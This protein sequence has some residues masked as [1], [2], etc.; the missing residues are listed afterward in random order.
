LS[1]PRDKD[2]ADKAPDEPH[3]GTVAENPLVDEPGD[4]KK[5]AKD[6]GLEALLDYLRQNRGY[7]FTGYKRPSLSR[8]IGKR[9]REVGIEAFS[10]YVDYLEVHPEE[11]GLLFDT[12]LINVTAF[13]RDM[14]AWEYVMR[15]VV[16]RIL[17]NKRADESI[18]LWSAGCAS[19]EE[20][21]TLAMVMAEAMGFEAFRNRVKIYATDIDEAALAHARQ[22]VYD[23]RHIEGIPE[24]LL[25]KYFET[26]NGRYSFHKDLRRSVI[27]GR[28]DLVQDAPIS[29]I[30][31]LACRNTLMYF[32]TET[33]ARILSRFHFALNEKGFLFLGKAETMQAYGALFTPVDFKLRVYSKVSRGHLR[34]RLA[35]LARNGNGGDLSYLLNHARLRDSAFDAGAVPQI[36][37]DINGL[38]VLA[39]DS[40]RKLFS[41]SQ[42]DLDQ[43]L[44]NLQISYRPVELRSCID[45]AYKERRNN[46]L[47]EVKWALEGGEPRFL[48]IHVVPL[49][50][51][52]GIL[53]GAS[54][55]FIDVSL[56]RR[57]KDELQATN[58]ALE[59]TN[60]ELQS[61]NEEL[62][63]TNEELQST[64]EELETTNEELQSTN[65]E[66]ETMNEELQSTN[67]E[68]E[69]IN[70][71][72]RQ[73]TLDLD[74]AN[75]FL[76]A[77]LTSLRS[78]VVVVDP[79]LSIRIWNPR[80]VDL[81]GLRADE[82][83]G[84][85]LLNLEIGLPLHELKQ[86]IR[87]CLSGGSKHEEKFVDAINRRG[88]AI[89]CV[90]AC[91]PL[92]E[93]GES[94]GVIL[95]IDEVE[96]AQSRSTTGA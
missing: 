38:V 26:S 79:D 37:I 62:E 7:D 88:K 44:Q 19:G 31:L 68:I 81:W 95:L 41:L 77:I 8:R 53:L 83:K 75:L 11:F 51:P 59:T 17:E 90:V 82:V 92:M 50:D 21:Y 55:L 22:A 85:N 80:S 72:L 13:F 91:A 74:Q 86:S 9:M 56:N 64:N 39:N 63:T 76:E 34:D 33:Q 40:A 66:L 14:P 54:V 16:P 4:G 30:D 96:D 49:Q 60:E 28:H 47:N 52:N 71:E 2:V 35:R 27:F 6:P 25:A 67:E 23:A 15:E 12:I 45:R 1:E 61:T 42:A 20:A 87:A 43:P 65:E 3:N 69:A 78:G 48:D 36:V 84:K 70:E 58:D 73:R 29:R 46:V 94:H 10:D 24:G 18:R 93:A 32:N 5:A 57:L 89:H